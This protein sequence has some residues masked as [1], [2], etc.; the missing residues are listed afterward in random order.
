MY[1][2]C[3]R[4]NFYIFT[5]GSKP[6]VAELVVAG[7]KEHMAGQSNKACLSNKMR[8]REKQKE[9]KKL[10]YAS[11]FRLFLLLFWIRTDISVF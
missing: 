6:R 7:V 4:F 5:W 2:L 10:F 11:L 8:E 3:I 9:V 1:K